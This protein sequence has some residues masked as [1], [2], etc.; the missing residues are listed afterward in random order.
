MTTT[1]MKTHPKRWTPADDANLD[2]AIRKAL[3]PAKPVD[4]FGQVHDAV[5]APVRDSKRSS[6]PIN[7]SSHHRQKKV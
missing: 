6:S 2:K 1:P 3:P 5:R 4:G 7:K